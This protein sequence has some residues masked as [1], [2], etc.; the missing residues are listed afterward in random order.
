[1]GLEFISFDIIEIKE[2]SI[3]ENTHLGTFKLMES[4]KL[5]EGVTLKSEKALVE[6]KL[7]KKVYN[8]DKDMTV[9]GG[10]ASDVLDNVPSVAVDSDGSAREPGSPV[11][12]S[13]S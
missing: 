5:L 6:I 9:K 13:T 4:S 8:V 12:I 7:D 11:S 3:Q 1:M 10:T 2:K